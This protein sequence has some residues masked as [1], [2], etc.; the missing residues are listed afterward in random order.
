[1]TNYRE[2]EENQLLPIPINT[3]FDFNIGTMTFDIPRFVEALIL[4]VSMLGILYLIL[5]NVNLGFG[6]EV[7]IYIFGVAA[8]AYLGLNGIQGH[9]LSKFI[10]NIIAFY[11][12]RRITH[13][14]PRVKKE[15]RFFTEEVDDDDYVIPRER[16]EALYHKYV[17]KADSVQANKN[18]QTE[19][20]DTS[21]MF[22]ED[23]IE[24]LGKPEELMSKKELKKLQK[25]KARE[26]KKALKLKKKEQRLN[27]K[28]KK[29]KGR[30]RKVVARFF[31]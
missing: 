6:T 18:L 30:N 14:N 7:T 26:E 8:A 16:L 23:D 10:M 2:E 31:N 13:Y 21:T 25:R 29:K 24:Y 28:A 4:S 11:K 3:E 20:L 5:S 15:I 19:E 22:F 12:N 1:M 9:R 27:D 17:N